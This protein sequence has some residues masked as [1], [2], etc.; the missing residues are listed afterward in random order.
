MAL[1]PQIAVDVMVVQ[2]AVEEIVAAALLLELE[3]SVDTLHQKVLMAAHN[4]M[5][6][7]QV[8]AV[9]HQELRQLDKQAEM[10]QH[11]P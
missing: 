1:T 7:V 4:Q 2:A 5:E 6:A 9:V 8:V 10:E 11:L 3:T